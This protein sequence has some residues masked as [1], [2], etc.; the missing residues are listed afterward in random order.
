MDT[1]AAREKRWREEATADSD[2]DDAPGLMALHKRI[3]RRI[4]KGR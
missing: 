2:A 4:T 3:K 1:I